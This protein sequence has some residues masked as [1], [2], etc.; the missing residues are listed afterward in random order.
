MG[1]HP[2][3]PFAGWK[4]RLEL[5]KPNVI[6]AILLAAA[7]GFVLGSEA[8]IDIPGLVFAL[9]GTA[10]SAA[11][12]N[13]LNQ[14]LEVERD[15]RMRRTAGR[16]LP[17]G[18]LRRAE[19]WLWACGIAAAGPVFL[20]FAVNPLSAGLAFA[21]E[22]VYVLLYTPL[23]P[24]TPFC[25]LVGAVCGA[26]PPL[27]GWTAA[28]GGLGFGGFLPAA[29]LFVWQMPHFLALGRLH[30]EDYAAGGFRVLGVGDE[31]G[32]TAG[33][34][35][36]VYSLALVPLGVGFAFLGY[37]GWVSAGGSVLLG[38]SLT[39][40]ALGFRRRGDVASARRLFRGSVAYVPLLFLLVLAGTAWYRPADLSPRASRADS[41]V[42]AT[43]HTPL[44]PEVPAR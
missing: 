2:T 21:A 11:G 15:R 13:A 20:L 18:R 34:M 44:H 32:N 37:R 43:A 6:P 29:V 19:A 7:M 1:I 33:R 31:R 16:P 24:R 41:P 42:S 40:L 38:I 12:A 28:T 36:V 26:M 39:A 4:A 9:L 23:K 10:L 17:S 5:A 3:G 35:A 8:A 22:A 25:T 30:R 27:I 14:C